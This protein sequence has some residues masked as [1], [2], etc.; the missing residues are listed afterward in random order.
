MEESKKE[1]RILKWGIRELGWATLINPLNSVELYSCIVSMLSHAQDL[2]PAISV[3]KHFF[4]TF[5]KIH[6]LSGD[7][8]VNISL[9]TDRRE[10]GG[11]GVCGGVCGGGAL[12]CWDVWMYFINLKQLH[13]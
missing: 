4:T 7:D 8:K 6:Y 1:L 2:P 10:V 9:E 3:S 12:W 5:G 11:T 13:R